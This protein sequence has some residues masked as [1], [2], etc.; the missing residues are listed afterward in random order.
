MGAS[1]SSSSGRDY[2]TF[3]LRVLKKD[4]DK[5]LDL[6]MDVLTQPTFPEEE[7]KREIE[8]TLAAIQSEEDQPDEVAEKA[9]QKDPLPEQPL[10]PSCRRD[11]GITSSTDTGGDCSILPDLLPS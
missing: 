6:F 4:L 11:K 2:A 8:K 10:W 1:L 5:G 3:S 9:F 7:I